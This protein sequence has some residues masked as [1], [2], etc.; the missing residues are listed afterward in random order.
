MVEC[1]LKYMST[2]ARVKDNMRYIKTNN[3][4]K[5]AKTRHQTPIGRAVVPILV[6]RLDAFPP[7]GFSIADFKARIVCTISA[8]HSQCNHLSLTAPE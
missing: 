6:F 2:D 1:C 7:P 5:P 3:A 8:A 4:R